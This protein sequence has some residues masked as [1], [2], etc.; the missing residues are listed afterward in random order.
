M[1]NK[2]ASL[3]RNLL[4][5]AAR[6]A[7][8]RGIK[9]RTILEELK[10][11]L[12]EEAHRELS[13][14]DQDPSTSRLSVMTGLQRKDVQKVLGASDELPRHTDLMTKIIGLWSASDSF[15]SDGAPNSLP[16]DDSDYSFSALVKSVSQDINPSTVLFE[17]ERLKLIKKEAN[18][19][20]LLWNSYQVSGDIDDA[21]ALLS[22]DIETLV[23]SVDCNITHADRTP[24]LHI[25]TSFDNVSTEALGQIKDWI[26]ERGA[27]FHAEIREYVGSFDKDLNPTLHAKSGGGRVTVGSFSLCTEPEA[28]DD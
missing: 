21:Y 18:A 2:S 10:T 7:I 27:L 24:N 12:L 11:T 1:T 5:P 15:S 16:L 4:R 25:S 20:H 17:L 19:V 9:I 22:S 3:L 23:R 14:V 8:R 6:F 28:S 26:L 13:R